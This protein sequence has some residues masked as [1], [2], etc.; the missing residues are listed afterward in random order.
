MC[1]K[2]DVEL[3][4]DVCVLQK[5]IIEYNIKKYCHVTIVLNN[6][7]CAFGERIGKI[8]HLSSKEKHNFF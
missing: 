2:G 3:T 1:D 5:Y 4:P 6:V 8:L 7:T